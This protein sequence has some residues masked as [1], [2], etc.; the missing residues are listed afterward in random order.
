MTSAIRQNITDESAIQRNPQG[1]CG[2][3]LFTV[4]A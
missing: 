3:F 1:L 4:A 2:V